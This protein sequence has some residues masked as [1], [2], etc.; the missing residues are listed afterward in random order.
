MSR[1]R[2]SYSSRTTVTQLSKAKTAT[3]VTI[4]YTAVQVKCSMTK[5]HNDIQCPGRCVVTAVRPQ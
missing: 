5:V 3:M 4:E 1:S 2:C